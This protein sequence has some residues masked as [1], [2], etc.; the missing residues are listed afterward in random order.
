MWATQKSSARRL[1]LTARGLEALPPSFP[2]PA[3]GSVGSFSV[4]GSPVSERWLCLP[5][6]NS[7]TWSP[8]CQASPALCALSWH[9]PLW[10]NPAHLQQTQ[11]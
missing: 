4:P 8:S 3:V 9:L 2:S 5:H 7:S 6:P 1:N 10:A 11:A